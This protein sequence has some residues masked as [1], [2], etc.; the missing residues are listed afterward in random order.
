MKISYQAGTCGS[1]EALVKGEK[2]RTCKILQWDV[3]L[4]GDKK[5][6]SD[7]EPGSLCMRKLAAKFLLLFAFLLPME[8]LSFLLST[9]DFP[10]GSSSSAPGFTCRAK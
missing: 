8:D 3:Q 2:F 9:T 10:S 5:R 4:S 1:F 7:L 6:P